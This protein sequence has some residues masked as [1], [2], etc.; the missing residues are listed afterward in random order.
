[1]FADFAESSERPEGGSNEDV[2]A[3]VAVSLFVLNFFS[4]VDVEKLEVGLDISVVL[5]V[6]LES[7]GDFFFE[8][9]NLNL[10]KVSGE[11]ETYV[12]LFDDLASVEHIWNVVKD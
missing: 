1:L 8:L 11:G 12:G 4:G 2:F 7:L 3:L 5:F 6:V 9:S 10:L